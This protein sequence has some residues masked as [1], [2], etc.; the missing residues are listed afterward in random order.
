MGVLG[1]VAVM[2]SDFVGHPPL[3]MAAAFF[4]CV[5]LYY[6]TIVLACRSYGSRSGHG[7]CSGCGSFVCGGCCSCSAVYVVAKTRPWL[8]F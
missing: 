2:E 1:T 4:V 6:C 7:R 8:D 3:E 5:L